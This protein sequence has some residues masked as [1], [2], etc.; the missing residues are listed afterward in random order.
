M[1]ICLATR[2]TWALGCKNTYFSY[3]GQL[4][5][6]IRIKYP[7][8]VTGSLAA[9]APLYWITG[10]GDRHGFWKSVTEQFGKSSQA[11][12][13]RVKEGFVQAEK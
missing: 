1:K 7:N 6:Y 4:A 13:D 10:F 3:G 8:L 5:A 12:V 11:C 9:S 2:Y